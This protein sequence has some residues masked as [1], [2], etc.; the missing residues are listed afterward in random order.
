MSLVERQ[1]HRPHYPVMP[2]KYTPV[3]AR[4]GYSPPLILSLSPSLRPRPRPLSSL[5]WSQPQPRLHPLIIYPFH[6]NARAPRHSYSLYLHGYLPLRRLLHRTHRIRIRI[7]NHT[8]NHSH[9]RIHIH[10]G[11]RTPHIR[12]QAPPGPGP[13]HHR[14]PTS[15]RSFH[16][17]TSRISKLRRTRRRSPR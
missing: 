5:E 2:Y 10:M 13:C 4:F 14:P 11:S 6:R 16:G 7:L 17:C 12:P 3:S 15:L 8:R 9:I 1:W